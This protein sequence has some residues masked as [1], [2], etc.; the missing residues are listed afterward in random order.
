[1]LKLLSLWFLVRLRG[2]VAIDCAWLLL[3]VCCFVFLLRLL[4]S[5]DCSGVRFGLWP[6]DRRFLL[7]WDF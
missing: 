1:M 5:A 7:V 3:L 6:V 2:L 4:V